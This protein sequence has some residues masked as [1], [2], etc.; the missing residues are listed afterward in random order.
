MKNWTFTKRLLLVA[1]LPLSAFVLMAIVEISSGY[2]NYSELESDYYDESLVKKVSE[3]I[4]HTQVE[5]GMSVGVLLGKVPVEKWKLHWQKTD[6]AREALKPHEK[7]EA[8][9]K[10]YRAELFKVLEE[11]KVRR[12]DVVTKSIKPPVTVANYSRMVRTLLKSYKVAAQNASY[13]ELANL[14][15]TGLSIED[16]R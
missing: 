12:D 11:Y 16:A 9:T 3:L 15:M 14:Y 4:K 10:E 8:L 6:K 7:S 13:P 1:L 5:R 2:L